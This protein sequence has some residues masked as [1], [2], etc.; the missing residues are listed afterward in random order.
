MLFRIY[1]NFTEENNDFN[2]YL[3]MINEKIY[4]TKEHL[5]QAYKLDLLCLTYIKSVKNLS[6]NINSKHLSFSL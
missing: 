5:L 2:Y 1:K 6:I 3:L 4:L